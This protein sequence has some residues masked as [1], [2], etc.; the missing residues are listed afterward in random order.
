MTITQDINVLN[1]LIK[2]NYPLTTSM[3]NGKKRIIQDFRE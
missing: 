3:A 2:K 1:L